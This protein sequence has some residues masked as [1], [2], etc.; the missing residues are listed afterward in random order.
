MRLYPGLILINI[1]HQYYAA[2]Y[3]RRTETRSNIHP[4][5][6]VAGVLHRRRKDRYSSWTLRLL[7]KIYNGSP[8]FSE[9][10]V[11][12]ALVLR[13]IVFDG[14]QCLQYPVQRNRLLPLTDILIID[15]IRD[16][17]F[18]IR[19]SIHCAIIHGYWWLSGAWR[20]AKRYEPKCIN[21]HSIIWW[22]WKL[23]FNN[24]WLN[25]I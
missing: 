14:V 21:F 8:S 15:V 16:V 4:P 2:I 22:M 3:D 18:L 23:P 19:E 7:S 12:P 13:D 17:I 11:F 9:E 10:C 20:T 24:Q 25:M 1:T 6:Y 5:K